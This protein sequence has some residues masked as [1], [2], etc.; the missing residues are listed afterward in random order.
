MHVSK[1]FESKT[2][3]KVISNNN[4]LPEKKTKKITKKK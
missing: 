3:K 4:Y 1:E 2:G